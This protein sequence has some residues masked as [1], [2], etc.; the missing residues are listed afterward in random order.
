MWNWVIENLATLLI[1]L[2]LVLLVVLIIVS[3]MR[4]RRHGK[5]ACSS[6]A[7]ASCPMSKRCNGKAP[8]AVVPPETAPA[9]VLP[10][11]TAIATPPEA[12]ATASPSEKIAG[13]KP[14][15][16]LRRK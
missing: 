13:T 9:A 6:Y 10:E 14:Q 11:A 12:T 2:G 8:N 4:K 7:C 16:H 3:M 15:V 5:N 1:S